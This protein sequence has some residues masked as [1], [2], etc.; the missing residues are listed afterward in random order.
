VDYI[1]EDVVH[2]VGREH[3]DK[4][5]NGEDKIVETMYSYA[6]NTKL[7]IRCDEEGVFFTIISTDSNKMLASCRTKQYT[8]KNVRG[9]V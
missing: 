2:Q 9:D 5:G 7:V 8:I 1:Y 3:V 6:V 4:N